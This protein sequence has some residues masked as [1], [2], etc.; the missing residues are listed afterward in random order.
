M[1]IE[2]FRENES[3]YVGRN[4]VTISQTWEFL[5][6]VYLCPF[7]CN[8]AVK[9]TFVVSVLAIMFSIKSMVSV[10]SA[11]ILSVCQRKLYHI[12][13]GAKTFRKVI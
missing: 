6:L 13:K 2:F 12:C 1:A 10:S 4:D 11:L 7:V 8:F 5:I 3:I 9:F